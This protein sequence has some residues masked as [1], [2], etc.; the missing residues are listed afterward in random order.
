MKT[1]DLLK[2]YH[3]NKANCC[4]CG[5]YLESTIDLGAT[6]VMDYDG[7]FYCMNCDSIFSDGDER[8][9]EEEFCKEGE[10]VMTYYETMVY[11]KNGKQIIF[12]D[13]VSGRNKEYSDCYVEMCYRC[14]NK[15]K[16]IL[17]NRI[18]EGSSPYGICSVRGC[19]N[20]ADRYVDF[21]ISDAQMLKEEIFE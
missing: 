17:E 2:L 7:N 16:D 3:S 20:E 4:R 10:N 9:F 14:L 6:F 5:C 8:I 19:S 12:D 13:F 21:D 18:D 11:S 15:Y 1:H